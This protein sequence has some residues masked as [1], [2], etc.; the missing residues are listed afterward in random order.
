[1]PTGFTPNNDGVNDLLVVHGLPGIEVVSYRIW[2]RWG[3]LLFEDSGFPV[4][5]TSRGWNGDFRDQ[6]V[7]G[8]VY[9]WQVEVRYPDD[10]TELFSGQTTLIR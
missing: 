4:N 9:L 2:D 3:E 10:R 1:V 5:D 8:G 6:P 7:N